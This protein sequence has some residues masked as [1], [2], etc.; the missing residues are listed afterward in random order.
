MSHGYRDDL[1]IDRI[2]VNG[3]YSPG[4]CRWVT[5]SEQ[6]KNKRVKNGY[7]IKE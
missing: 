6:N 7:K 1:T 5:M 3:N 2:D 4:N